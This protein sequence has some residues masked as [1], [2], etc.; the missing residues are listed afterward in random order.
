MARDVRVKV[1]E[2]DM[3]KEHSNP[4]THTGNPMEEADHER[5]PKEADLGQQPQK[6]SPGEGTLT[7]QMEEKSSVTPSR[8][9]KAT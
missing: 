9:T 7:P 1:E 3:T 6:P 2:S 8:E 5:E 4:R